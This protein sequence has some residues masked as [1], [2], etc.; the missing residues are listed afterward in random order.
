MNNKNHIYFLVFVIAL[1][2][3][4]RLYNF[5]SWSLS[6]DEL[7]AVIRLQATTFTQLIEEGVKPDF[8]PAGVQIFLYYW[9]KVVGN[10]P[11]ALRLPFVLAGIF[12]VF[13]FYLI[14]KIWFNKSAAILSSLVF[15]FLQFT[16]L[17]SQL[18]R[19]YSVGLFFSLIMVFGLTQLLFNESQKKRLNYS[20]L[21]GTGIIGCMYT[22]YFSF[23]FAIV[24]GITGLFFIRKE[25]FWHYLIASATAVILFL[26]HLQI[27]LLQFGRGGVGSWLGKP[28]SDYLG[29]FLFYSFNESWLLITAL[30]FSFTISYLFN[31]TNWQ[32]NKFRIISLVW[33]FAPFFIGYYYSIYV[34]PVLQYSI[35]IFSFP[36]LLLFVFSY[37]NENQTALNLMLFVPLAIIGF[38]STAFGFNYYN[39]QQFG[40]FKQLA[41]KNIEWEGKYGSEN[42]N[43]AYNLIAWQ[44]VDYYFAKENYKAGY[45]FLRGD[46]TISKHTLIQHVSKSN[47]D[48][49]VFGWSN[50][51]TPDE[52][53]SII[54]DKY[55]EVMEHN[56]YFNSAV[57][58]FKKTNKPNSAKYNL[59]L[60]ESFDNFNGKFFDADTSRFTDTVITSLCINENEDFACEYKTT[61]ANLFPDGNELVNIELDYSTVSFPQFQLV[62]EILRAGKQINWSSGLSSHFPTDEQNNGTLFYSKRKPTGA[63]PSDE[64]KIYIWN[65][66]KQ[67]ITI[68]NILI[69]GF[70]QTNQLINKQ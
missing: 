65:L 67:N 54:L 57:T 35:L 53:F 5:S 18:A 23:L 14:A 64:V 30:C 58:L 52:F 61:I 60:N 34:N 1:A 46:D 59:Y 4:M 15:G 56:Q 19:P 31:R 25:N 40:V 39:K 36:F 32:K 33:F 16:I 2:A 6:N 51:Y 11:F 70:K 21:F 41:E 68:D 69:F 9:C 43:T 12:S 55:D 38:C 66:K 62:F 44:Y 17:Y 22:H 37:I 24:V 27:T 42:V 48:Y 3:L 49:F 50:V 47:G 45:C 13:F 28:E 63:L 26:P 7:S 29:Q 20:F 8:H 10:S